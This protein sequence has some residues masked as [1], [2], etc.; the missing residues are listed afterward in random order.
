MYKYYN[1][2][3]QGKN[4]GD[5]TIRAISKALDISWTEAYAGITAMG[6]MLADMPSANYVW[7]AYLN[8]NGFK[9]RLVEQDYQYTV[10]DFCR[11]NPSGTYVLALSNHVVCVKDGVYYDS[12]DSGKELPLYVWEK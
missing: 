4:V 6:F 12:W 9:R 5:C 3:P 7:G 2:N 10:E 8:R 11:D 1:P